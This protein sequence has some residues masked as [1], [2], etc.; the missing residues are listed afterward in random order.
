MSSLY[1]P[2]SEAELIEQLVAQ[3][4]RHDGYVGSSKAFAKERRVRAAALKKED[5]MPSNLEEQQDVD[6]INRQR[7]WP[8]APILPL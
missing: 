6:A 8:S 4:L 1:A 7:M 3:F 2:Y 5:K